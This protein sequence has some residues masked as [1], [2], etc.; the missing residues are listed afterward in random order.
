VI[1]DFPSSFLVLITLCNAPY[2]LF[3]SFGAVRRRQ[4]TFFSA[5][6]PVGRRLPFFLI[7]LV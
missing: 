2:S 6:L 4:R 1:S 3:S 5:Q 7:L